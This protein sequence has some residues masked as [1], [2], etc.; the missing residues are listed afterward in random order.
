MSL[1]HGETLDPLLRVRA[2]PRLQDERLVVGEDLEGL[3]DVPLPL[4]GHLHRADRAHVERLRDARYPVL[5]KK[6]SMNEQKGL[7][8]VSRSTHRLLIRQ[9]GPREREVATFPLFEEFPL[10][11]LL[12]LQLAFDD[13]LVF[14][15]EGDEKLVEITYHSPVSNFFLALFFTFSLLVNW[16]SN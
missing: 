8:K 12:L 2:V 11:A 6:V 3:G 10:S 5:K 14:L 4:L 15:V 7:A 13:G 1:G 16:S 9:F